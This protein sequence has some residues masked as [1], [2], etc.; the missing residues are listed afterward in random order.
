MHLTLSSGL[1][2]AYCTFMQYT[3]G[4]IKQLGSITKQLMSLKADQTPSTFW[5]KYKREGSP[6]ISI[7]TVSIACRVFF[8]DSYPYYSILRM[9]LCL[10]AVFFHHNN[11]KVGKCTAITS[12]VQGFLNHLASFPNLWK[13]MFLPVVVEY[14]REYARMT[15][16]EILVEDGVIIGQGFGQ[17]RQPQ[18]RSLILNLLCLFLVIQDHQNIFVQALGVV[19]S[20][21]FPC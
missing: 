6:R 10:H 12:Q 9:T 15:I 17:P 18:V 19:N 8:V 14:L 1:I 21:K 11:N 3:V 5:Q 13:F 7:L 4:L 20:K 16:E 2:I